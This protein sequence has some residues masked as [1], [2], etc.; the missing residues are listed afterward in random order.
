MADNYNK[1]EFKKELDELNKLR[2]KLGEESVN[3]KFDT[4][5]VAQLRDD[6]SRV[7]DIID[8]TQETVLGL[9]QTWRKVQE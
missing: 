1:A 2:K 6:L 4:S 7:K 8:D 3:I 5:G 9:S